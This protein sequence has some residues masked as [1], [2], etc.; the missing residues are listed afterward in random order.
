[1]KVMLDNGIL[2]HSQFAEGNLITTEIFWNGSNH[3]VQLAGFVRK[4]IHPDTAYQNEIDA[5]FTIGRMIRERRVRAF[6]YIELSFEKIK[7]QMGESAFDALADCPIERCKVPLERSRFFQTIDFEGYVAK[8]GKKDRKAGMDTSM[9]QISFVELLLSL[10]EGHVQQLI[11]HNDIF[12]M[13]SFEVESLQ[14]LSWFRTMCRVSQSPENYP[15]MLHLWAAQRNHMDVF[16]TLEK[17]LPNIAAHLPTS[18]ACVASFPTVVLRPLALLD[19]LGVTELDPVPIEPQRF[20][21]IVGH[22]F[23]INIE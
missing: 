2:S 21:P 14:N 22:S 19:R 9:S 7:R 8:G 11:S 5:L 12:G 4:K 1:M 17:R 18:T 23:P 10:E 15:D 3:S 16:L 13:S 6:S 20:Y